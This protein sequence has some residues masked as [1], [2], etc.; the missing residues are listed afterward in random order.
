MRLRKEHKMDEQ[1]NPGWRV[2]PPLTQSK[3]K[4]AF[5]LELSV[6]WK[7]MLEKQKR[8]IFFSVLLLSEHCYEVS[9]R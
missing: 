7:K 6:D 1:L 9:L 2:E 5:S 4:W 8:R 3:R